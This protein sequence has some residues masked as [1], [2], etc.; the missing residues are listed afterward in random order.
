MT[1][2]TNLMTSQKASYGSHRVDG[3]RVNTIFENFDDDDKNR[4]MA[5]ERERGSS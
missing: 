3:I 1:H 2:P 5:M 4:Y